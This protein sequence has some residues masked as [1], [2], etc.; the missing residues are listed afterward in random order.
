MRPM[1]LAQKVA[2]PTKTIGGDA[3]ADKLIVKNIGNKD[4]IE[5]SDPAST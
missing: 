1:Q 3:V 2:D 4:E 5:R